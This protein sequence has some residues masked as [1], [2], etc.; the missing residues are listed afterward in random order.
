[1][2]TQ[3]LVPLD[4][5]ETAEKVLPYS[6]YLAGKL[7]IPV[8]LLAV[9]DMADTVTDITEDRSRCFDTTIDDAVR[10]TENY[11]SVVAK[12][13]L[14]AKVEC[15]VEK[16]EADKIIIAKGESD[17]RT[18]ITMATHGRSGLARFLLG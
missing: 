2:F 13:F 17:R 5:S 3:M 9:I 7:K 15:M 10:K 8:R 18:L 1:M 6:R 12:T 16:G 4:G 14:G 11:L